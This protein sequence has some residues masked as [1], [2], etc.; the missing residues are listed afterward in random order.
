MLRQSLVRLIH[1]RS[2]LLCLQ[3]SVGTA[4]RRAL[5]TAQNTGKGLDLTWQLLAGGAI[6]G[7]STYIAHH[8]GYLGGSKSGGHHDD[9]GHHHQK[10]DAS[11]SAST[12]EPVLVKG[13]PESVPF[14]IV[15]G[16]TAAFAA[17]RAIRSNNPKARVLLISAE[18]HYP[19]MRPPL[20]KELWYSGSEVKKE[21]TFKQWNGREKSIFFEHEE[22]YLPL[23]QFE[24]APN[25]G[26]TVVKG[27]RVVKIDATDRKAFLE[28]G[29]II[30]YGKCLIAT[31]GEPKNLQV[32]EN[33]APEIENRVILYR[34]VDDFK[35]LNELFSKSK[36]ITIIG[37]GLLGSELACALADKSRRAKAKVQLNQLMP[38]QGVLERILPQ[39]LSNWCSKKVMEEGILIRCHCFHFSNYIC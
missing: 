29:Q 36:S 11:K 14:L 12:V 9:D 16:G 8:Y 6:A 18:N 27:Q 5:S 30:S 21:F 33:V 31:G 32:F 13:L 2:S 15:G 39:Y 7:G 19:Y 28:N 35:R 26:I 20:S 10:G 34:T 1:S 22:F 3:L 17:S 25:G 23:E 24:S 4:K 38:E 37:G